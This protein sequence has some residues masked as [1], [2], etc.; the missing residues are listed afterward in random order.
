MATSTRSA[1]SSTY[2]SPPAKLVVVGGSAGAFQAFRTI[3]SGLPGHLPYPLVLVLHQLPGRATLLPGLI[4]SACRLAVSS[5][6]DKEA[7][8]ADTIYVAP[9]DYHLLVEADGTLAL[10]HDPPENFS[11][12]SIDVLFE[13]AAAAFGEDL[14]AILLSG[15]NADGARGLGAVRAAG[16]RI[17]VQDPTTADADRMPRAGIA[18]VTPDAILSPEQITA[19]LVELAGAAKKMS[20]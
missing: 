18:A 9:P 17:I 19:Y 12:P 13:S 3:V 7:L 8:V 4:A 6:L 16:G 15:A 5:C 11:R 1:S 14:V 2:A 10:S 20:S